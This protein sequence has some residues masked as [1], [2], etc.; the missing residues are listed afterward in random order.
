M[1]RLIPSSVNTTLVDAS[2]G[3]FIVT[4]KYIKAPVQAGIVLSDSTSFAITINENSDYKFNILEAD[5]TSYTL[6]TSVVEKP[7]VST[8]VNPPY[9]WS[10]DVGT[11]QTT[12]K[13]L[14]PAD[15]SF[16]S[17]HYSGYRINTSQER[18]VFNE[19]FIQA[20]GVSLNSLHYNN[21]VDPVKR[22]IKY[23]RK[24]NY[25]TR[26]QASTSLSYKIYSRLVFSFG[27]PS[28]IQTRLQKNFITGYRI[29]KSIKKGYS[30]NYTSVNRLSKSVNLGYE[31]R[32]YNRLSRPLNISYFS[33]KSI[34]TVQPGST[35]TVSLM[36]GSILPATL[37]TLTLPDNTIISATEVTITSSNKGVI[38]F[39]DGTSIPSDQVMVNLPDGSIVSATKVLISPPN[40]GVATLPDGTVTPAGTTV[41]RTQ[42]VDILEVEPLLII[43]GEQIYVTEM[44]ISIDEGNYTYT[45]EAKLANYAD[46]VKFQA[47]Q[48]F[49]AVLQ[50]ET[51]TFVVD[52]RTLNRQEINAPVTTV[53]GLSPTCAFTGPRS[54]QIIGTT[55]SDG[56][57]T[58]YGI[59]YSLLYDQ[60]I[61]YTYQETNGIPPIPPSTPPLPPVT[62]PVVGTPPSLTVAETSPWNI[63]VGLKWEILDWGVPPMRYGAENVYPLDAV[64]N[65]VEA[66]GGVVE[67][68]PSG[69]IRVRYKHPVRV[70]DYSD[71]TIS[72]SFVDADDIISIQ[73]RHNP[74][75]MVNAVYVKTYQDMGV[76]DQIEFFDTPSLAGIN[77]FDAIPYGGIVRVFPA[78]WRTE[79]DIYLPNEL[80][81]LNPTYLRHNHENDPNVT[82]EYLGVEDWIPNTWVSPD[83]GWE[84]IDIVRSQGTAR[85]PVVKVLSHGYLSDDAGDIVINDY[86]KT[87]YTK[88]ESV[89][90]SIVKL[91]YQTRCHKWRLRAPGGTHIQLRIY[92]TVYNTY[93]R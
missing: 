5:N 83:Y 80:E 90:F 7:V 13:D 49:Y 43:N 2:G 92:D 23:K 38:T 40:N 65:I 18:V 86:S 44:S 51:Y 75:R 61:N 42:N 37:V 84:T 62:Q 56:G 16:S 71:E 4:V 15:V 32:D 19:G 41:T 78:V 9:V 35:A 76:Q 81:P 60:H 1:K 48:L 82:L 27:V 21:G 50:G 68:T 69:D 70:P 91:K 6:T 11:F 28:V 77:G 14:P 87:F 59:S 58:A 8:V 52:S 30:V 63:N 25:G 53:R 72:H 12:Y 64:K 10:Y 3:S 17:H 36:D 34:L 33:V 47:N 39:F 85:Y 22:V 54:K 67:S 20:N 66:V 55:Y 45:L 93:L 24:V 79:R 31:I 46:L 89:R 29:V 74:N 88:S 26:I 57:L 73:E